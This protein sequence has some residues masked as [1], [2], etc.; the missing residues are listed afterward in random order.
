MAGHSTSVEIT[1][2]HRSLFFARRILRRPENLAAPLLFVLRP[3]HFLTVSER[4]NL[5]VQAY[6]TS[7]ALPCPHSEAQIFAFIN[8][9]LKAPSNLPGCVV[10]AGCF[11]GT[12]T[13]KFSLAARA[14][15]R[16]LIVFDSFEGMPVH[17]ER[18]STNMF[19]RPV[20]F[21]P[22]S[23][24]GKLQEVE[25]NLERFGAP[26]VCRL[27]K[28][29]FE[30]TMPGFA[31]PVV[32]AYIDVDLVS[33]TRTCLRQLYPLLVPGG[34][35]FSQDGHLPLVVNL[36]RDEQFWTNDI[37]CPPPPIYGLGTHKLVRILK[38]LVDA[39]P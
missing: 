27:V 20:S 4:L 3:N 1:G 5:V 8:A 15:G 37:G 9:I 34:V 25:R 39:A 7:Y 12:S 30:E 18:H 16:Q 32:A 22:G 14:A 6:R 29:W 19:G 24:C 21:P 26:E 11:K 23:Y 35:L 28:G 33:S 17:D 31:Q 38:P 2:W 13:A 10:E 36:L